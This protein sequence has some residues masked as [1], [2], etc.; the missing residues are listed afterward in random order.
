[1]QFCSVCGLQEIELEKDFPENLL[2]CGGYNLEVELNTGKRRAGIY[3]KNGVQY[4]RR[5]DLETE[6]CHVLF[7]FC[8]LAA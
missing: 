4:K 8:W 2:N 6:N 5:T 1:M 7:F 3:I